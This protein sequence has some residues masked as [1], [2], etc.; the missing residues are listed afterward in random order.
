MGKSLPAFVLVALVMVLLVSCAGSVTSTK[1]AAQ[2]KASQWDE[3]LAAA[4][5]EGQVVILNAGGGAG[6][7]ESFVQGMKALGI[8]AAVTIGSGSA[9]ITRIRA[10]RQAGLHNPDI[11]IGGYTTLLNIAKPEGIIDK[12]LDSQLVLPDVTDPER[13]KKVWYE[14]HFW[15]ADTDHSVFITTLQP[16]PTIAINTETVKDSDIKSYKDLLNPRWSGRIMQN[17]PTV[18]GAGQQV[19][20]ALYGI[21]GDDF[22]RQLVATKPALSREDRVMLNWLAQKK[23]DIVIGPDGETVIEFEKAGAPI[24]II[25]PAEGVHASAA[26]SGV[27]FVKKAPHPNAAR[28]FLNWITTKEGQT[29]FVKAG[30]LH[31]LRLDVPTDH[32]RPGQM[33]QPGVK[34]YD[35]WSE[36]SQIVRSVQAAKVAKELYEPLKK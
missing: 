24:K 30:A 10:E 17:D 21:M 36:E 8:D 33:R 25:V 12:P 35:A 22:I 14:G 15:W 31:S 1:Q 23:V 3:M 2:G 7:R 11:W 28:A 19:L 5:L 9:F 4:K 32:L 13:I 16:R 27:A 34:Y 18:S 29:A 6:E 20:Q 26:S